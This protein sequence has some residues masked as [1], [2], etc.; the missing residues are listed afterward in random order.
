MV[1]TATCLVGGVVPAFVRAEAPAL[2]QVLRREGCQTGRTIRTLSEDDT[3]ELLSVSRA[4]L[5]GRHREFTPDDG[6]RI[7]VAFASRVAE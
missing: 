7:E 1:T 4:D 3:V 5:H 2:S 6:P